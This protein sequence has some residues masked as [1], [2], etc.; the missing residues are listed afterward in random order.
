MVHIYNGIISHK[1]NEIMPFAVNLDGP[2]DY[3]TKWSKSDRKRQISYDITYMCNLITNDTG[4]LTYKIETDP[5]IS[6]SNLRL[7]KGKKWGKMI[8]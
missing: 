8:N 2:R 5:Q 4:E 3:H 6:K 1:T 7:P